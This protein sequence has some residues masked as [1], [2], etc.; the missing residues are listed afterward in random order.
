MGHCCPAGGHAVHLN[1]SR[2]ASVGAFGIPAAVTQQPFDMSQICPAA[3]S[4]ILVH[5]VHCSHE[6]TFPFA[7]RTA[8]APAQYM[9][10]TERK[11]QIGPTTGDDSAS[12][13]P[14]LHPKARRTSGAT[15][16]TR[17][18]VEEDRMVSYG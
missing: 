15:Y 11:S 18:G 12:T 9:Y 16:R 8:W 4:A 7:L 14:A 13:L 1:R 3:Q 6:V 10:V 17:R 2:R 5:G